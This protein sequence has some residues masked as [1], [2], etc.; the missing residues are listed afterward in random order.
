MPKGIFIIT[1]I[2]LYFYIL[3]MKTIFLVKLDSM[4]FSQSFYPPSQL[5]GGWIITKHSL[6]LLLTVGPE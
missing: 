2:F 3:L 4:R 6:R 5:P 1:Y